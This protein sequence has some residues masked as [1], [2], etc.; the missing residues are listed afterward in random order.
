MWR[1]LAYACVVV[2]AGCGGGSVQAGGQPSD[3]S[4]GASA[5][6][7]V[8]TAFDQ[9]DSPL[10]S[11]GNIEGLKS[12]ET[13]PALDASIA[14]INRAA[15]QG[16]TQPGFSHTTPGFAIP[17][18]DPQCFLVV[19]TLKLAGEELARTDL[20][21]FTRQSAGGWKLS[22]NILIAA[23]GIATAR[24]AAG[25]AAT[26][27]HSLAAARLQTVA[28]QVFDRTTGHTPDLTVVAPNAALDQQLAAG[29]GIYSQQMGQAGFAVSRA[30]DGTDWSSC[31]APTAA[32]TVAF[33]TLHVTDTV[34]PKPGGPKTALL[35]PQSPDLM[36][37]GHH[38][39]VSGKKVTVNRVEVFAL[40]VPQSGP[41]VILGL[42]DAA[43]AV[44]AI[45]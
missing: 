3:A 28:Q 38:Q 37:T 7:A 41:A 30:L 16:R 23:D 27:A 22:H 6:T 4:F 39:P 10:S 44:T 8:L 36:A 17:A 29:W 15:A 34:A 12:Q 42:S 21:Q 26:D 14:G 45:N 11:A 32:G 24:G 20:S 1:R 43:T 33:L 35:P 25:V 5:A 2:V 19:A 31:V 9:A 18:G 13:S 40:C